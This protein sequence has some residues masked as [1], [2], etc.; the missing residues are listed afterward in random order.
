MIITRG[1]QEGDRVR[2]RAE[3]L[4]TVLRSPRRGGKHVHYVRAMDSGEW[5]AAT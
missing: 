2:V 1:I 3:V 4:C 5:R